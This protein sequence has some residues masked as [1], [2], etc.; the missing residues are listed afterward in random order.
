MGGFWFSAKYFTLPWVLY[1]FPL[2]PTHTQKE[3]TK[4]RQASLLS[5]DPPI[6][7]PFCLSFCFLSLSFCNFRYVTPVYY[8]FCSLCSQKSPGG[9]LPVENRSVPRGIRDGAQRAGQ[10]RPRNQEF[11][12]PFQMTPAQ[13]YL[14]T[15]GDRPPWWLR[16]EPSQGESFLSPRSLPPSS[17][18][19]SLITQR[20]VPPLP[21][22]SHFIV[23][24]DV[25]RSKITLLLYMFVCLTHTMS[26]YK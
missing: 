11:R 5:A 1:S 8:L 10:N 24:I 23:F 7:L 14:W 15:V 12:F 17:P 22:L 16:I 6:F 19:S 18:E 21:I 26:L 3:D 2:K 13:F 9:A 20:Q 25:S 4:K